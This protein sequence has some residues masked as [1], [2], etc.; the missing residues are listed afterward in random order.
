MRALLNQVAAI[1]LAMRAIRA[2]NPRARLIQTE[3]CGRTFSTPRLAYQ[4]EF[5]NHRRWLTFDLL[6]GRVD[7]RPSVA[8]RGW[9]RRGAHAEASGRAWPQHP[10]PPD[11]VGLNY[12]LTSDRFLD[13]R[14]DR[15]PGRGAGGNGR[16]VYADV[17]AVAR[18]R[19]GMPDTTAS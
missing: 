13:H 4:A 17:E 7:A 12:Y 8:G 16:H 6:T 19:P 15:Y 5:E 18:A 10:C 2:V 3:D 9:S 11:V 14:L 1:V